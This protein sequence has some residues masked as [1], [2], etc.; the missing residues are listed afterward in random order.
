MAGTEFDRDTVETEERLPYE[1][2]E[3]VDCGEVA[4]VTQI[5]ATNPGIDGLYS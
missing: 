2:P 3:I 5:G 4:R 1:T